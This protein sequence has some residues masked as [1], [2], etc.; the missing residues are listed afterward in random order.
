MP[1]FFSNKYQLT[2]RHL[3]FH[4]REAHRKGVRHGQGR[5][6]DKDAK[7]EANL[8]LS[9]LSSQRGAGERRAA[10]TRGRLRQGRGGRGKP[11]VVSSFI[12]ERSRGKEGGTDKGA[13]TAR[14]RRR[15]QMGIPARQP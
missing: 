14:M 3:T 5:G 9:P 15:R 6:H 8:S 7:A 2:I 10:R 1:D 11:F 4:R 12:A 13:V